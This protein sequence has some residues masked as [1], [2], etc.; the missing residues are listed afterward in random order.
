MLREKLGI[1]EK[2]M[3]ISVGRFSYLNGYGKGYDV[4]LKAAAK[5]RKL[6][7]GWYIIGGKP[8]DEFV[9]MKKKMKLENVHFWSLRKRRIKRI[10]SG[11]RYIYLDDHRR[12]VGIGN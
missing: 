3:V 1:K 7:V 10:L 12:C 11:C 2:Y 9:K 5:V 4:I 6:D 8:T